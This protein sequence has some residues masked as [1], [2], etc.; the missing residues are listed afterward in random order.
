MATKEALQT[1]TQTKEELAVIG[2][3]T[4]GFDRRAFGSARFGQTYDRTR[5]REALQTNSLTKEAL[6]TN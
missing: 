6:Q 3:N 1:N 4:G 5:T 2:T